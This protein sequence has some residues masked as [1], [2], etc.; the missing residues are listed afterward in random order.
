MVTESKNFQPPRK[1]ERSKDMSKFQLPSGGQ[2][3]VGKYKGP[4]SDND[5]SGRY[6]LDHFEPGAGVHR[7]AIRLV[8][9]SFVQA[10]KIA[11]ALNT[12]DISDPDLNREKEE[13]ESRY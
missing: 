8:T 10:Q 2:F 1:L 6:W 13:N 11:D 7:K 3:M 12:A 9:D 5:F 4:Q